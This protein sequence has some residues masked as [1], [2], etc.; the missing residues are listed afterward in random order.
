MRKLYPLFFSIFILQACKKWDKPEQVPAYIHID[1]LDLSVTSTQGT[2]S[3]AFIDAWVYVND[4]PVG[5]FNLPA[6]IPMLASG[7]QKISIYPG[8]K[9]DGLTEHRG[10][11]TVC[12]EYVT[13]AVNLVPGEIVDMSGANQPVITYYPSTKIDIWNENFEDPAV[14][15]TTDPNSEAGIVYVDDTVNAFEG[16][17][18]GK[19]EL[20]SGFTYAR[21][22]TAQTFN[23]PKLGKSVYVELNYN[24]NNT[25]AIGLQA[26]DGTELSSKDYVVLNATNGEWKK[27]YVK[28]GELVSSYPNAD[29]FK[30]I[31]TVDKDNGVDAVVNYVDNFKVVYVK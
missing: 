24:T 17:G 11:Y 26:I 22:L 31:I 13:T 29:V 27:V 15:F 6:T 25:M 5:V 2:A 21:V 18:M 20:G 28:F 12:Q 23:L 7:N 4:Q 3:H 30:F 1:H 16:H 9:E 14:D 8:I 19:I 10:K